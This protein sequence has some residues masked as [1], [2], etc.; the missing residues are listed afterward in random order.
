MARPMPVTNPGTGTTSE[1][2]S[3]QGSWVL[4]LVTLLSLLCLLPS[5]RGSDISCQG[6]RYMYFNKGLDTSNIPRTP[7]QGER[8]ITFFGPKNGAPSSADNTFGASLSR[9]PTLYPISPISH[10]KWWLWQLTDSLRYCP[11][12]LDGVPWPHRWN[13]A[14]GPCYMKPWVKPCFIREGTVNG[15]ELKSTLSHYDYHH[16]RLVLPMCTI[17]CAVFIWKGKTGRYIFT[18]DLPSYSILHPLSAPSFFSNPKQPRLI[19][20]C[21]V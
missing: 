3:S 13:M 8:L 17:Q 20:I 11:I 18:K 6:I 10:K 5:A 15:V 4:K 2:W 21:S 19:H 9:V 1:T 12:S 7:Q 14:F 16:W